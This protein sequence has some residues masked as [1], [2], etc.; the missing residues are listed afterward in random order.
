MGGKPRLTPVRLSTEA[1]AG[2]GERKYYITVNLKGVRLTSP[3]SWPKHE[4]EQ[5][6]AIV[7]SFILLDE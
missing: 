2:W 7:K 4:A 6:L 1:H 5:K 3:R